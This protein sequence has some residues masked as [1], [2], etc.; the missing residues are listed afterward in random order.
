[1][2]ASDA[3]Q[4]LDEEI[5]KKQK[6]EQEKRKKQ[7]AIS[8]SY[9]EK[10]LIDYIG[11]QT[12]SF[13]EN[14]KKAIAAGK[15]KFVMDCNKHEFMESTVYSAIKNGDLKSFFSKLQ[16]DGFTINTRL[17]NYTH[18]SSGIDDPWDGME[19]WIAEI[20]ASW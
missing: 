9:Y 1:M 8:K 20:T 16:S 11:Y 6:E 3:R 18:H 10:F 4:L 12:K 17:D 7:L 15:N 5:N 13:D 2:K 19:V 14:V